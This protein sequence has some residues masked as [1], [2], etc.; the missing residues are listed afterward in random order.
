MQLAEPAPLLRSLTILNEMG[1][2]S[3][4][5]QPEQDDA[6]EELVARKM[7]AGVT[8]YIVPQRKP[9]QRGALKK[10]QKLTDPAK[11]REHRA[12][13]LSDAD[14]SKFVLEGKGEAIQSPAP[15]KIDKAKRAKTAKEVASGHSV[16][17]QPRR[18]G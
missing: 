8:F 3:I 14:F 5:W 2:T 6:M 17:V 18:G 1:D 9:G 16:G 7:A 13:A 12:L 15:E 11:A 4:T 10:P